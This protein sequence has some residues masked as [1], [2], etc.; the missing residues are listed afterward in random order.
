[1]A[2]Q[3][4]LYNA[5]WTQG[6]YPKPWKKEMVIRLLKA[7]KDP[8]ENRKTVGSSPVWKTLSSDRR[9][10]MGTGDIILLLINWF[11]WKAQF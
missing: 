2:T 9:P 11:I 7:G 6:E 10:V 5:M 3:L 8:P 1:M 4:A